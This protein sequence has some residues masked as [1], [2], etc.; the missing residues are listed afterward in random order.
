ML[1][2][3]Q[4]RF[5]VRL[6]VL[7]VIAVAIGF[8][9]AAMVGAR[10]LLRSSERLHR[11]SATSLAASIGASVRTTMLEG[12]GRM[13][14]QLVA[15]VKSRVPSAGV[16]VFSAQG[17]EVFGEKGAAPPPNQ[18]PAPVRDAIASGKTVEKGTA[19]SLPIMRGSRCEGC[20][21]G[22]PM[23]GVLTIDPASSVQRSKTRPLA[24]TDS[25]GD[26]LDAFTEIIRDGFYRVMLAPRTPRFDEYF[27]AVAARVP[28]VRGVAV[29]SPTRKLA[30]GKPLAMD[31]SGFVRTVTLLAE[32]RCLGCHEKKESIDSSTLIVA[33]DGPKA[34]Q[35]ETLTLLTETVLEQVMQAGLGRL[36]TG[37]LDDVGQGGAVRALTL[38]DAEGRLFHDA[39]R[40]PTPPEDVVSAL[41]TGNA[42]ANADEN[43]M[44]F[45]FVEPLRN[46]KTCEKCHGSDQA[47]RGVIEVRYSDPEA[48]A[49]RASLRSASWMFGG[50]T[51]VLVALLLGFG[52]AY[53]KGRSEP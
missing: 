51:V 48:L 14:R 24:A 52:L 45:R 20:H 25:A 30:Y 11:E 38:H 31:K 4:Q 42:V 10:T 41:R 28:G 29:Y 7:V 37:F 2:K 6:G 35:Q 40:H 12:D 19:R 1:D 53:L 18:V 15:E 44:E 33:F 13:V 26:N 47:M 43:G 36:I 8:A 46:V 32:P 22:R 49:E 21:V 9:L 50:S 17:D 27:T 23:L 16:R 5:A 3:T 34:S 39:F